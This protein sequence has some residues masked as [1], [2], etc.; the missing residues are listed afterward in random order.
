MERVLVARS[1]SPFPGM[2]LGDIEQQLLNVLQAAAPA[3]E[4]REVDVLAEEVSL[5]LTS[6][7]PSGQQSPVSK[8]CYV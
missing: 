3:S 8:T 1:F 7:S 2:S 6:K 5:H 4:R